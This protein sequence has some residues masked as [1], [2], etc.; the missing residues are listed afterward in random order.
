MQTGIPIECSISQNALKVSAGNIMTLMGYS[1]ENWD[2]TIHEMVA[3]AIE[4]AET[5]FA[6]AAGYVCLETL[7]RAEHPETMV[8]GTQV[9]ETKRRIATQ[10]KNAECVAVYVCTIGDALERIAGDCMR[11]GDA[12]RAYLFDLIAS[13]AVEAL[14]S[15][16]HQ[17]VRN[18]AAAHSMGSSNRFSPGYCEWDVGEQHLLFSLLPAGFCGVTLAASAL[19]HPVKST[20]GFIGIGHGVKEKN[21]SCDFCNQR[22]CT[23]RQIRKARHFSTQTLPL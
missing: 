14:A 13:E 6:P 18:I 3:V 22:N 7:Q 8:V 21:Y 19:M 5:A 12:L 16:L 11:E 10:L 15:I 4:A 20:S 9:F 17:H 1:P 2:P 23:F